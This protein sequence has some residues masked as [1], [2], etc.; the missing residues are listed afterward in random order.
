MN[1]TVFKS[2][3]SA[4][5]VCLPVV[6]IFSMVACSQDQGTQKPV[7]SNSNQA[8][9]NVL[10]GKTDTIIL[11]SANS[12]QLIL[13]PELSGRVLGA[14]IKGANDENLMWVDKTITDGSFWT[15][16]PYFW[17]AGGLRTW[18]APED[19]FFV[20][21]KK[22]ADSWF[23]PEQ[24]D[25]A[26]F[27]VIEKTGTKASFESDIVLPANIGKDYKVTLKRSIELLTS[28]PSVLGSL[29]AGIE[30]MGIDK[31]H[32]LTNNSDMVIG[33]D[34][35]YVCL[36]SLLQVNPS[37]TMLIP[38]KAGADPKTSYREYFNPLGDR[39][40]VQNGIIS[41]K[42]DGKYRSKIG[43]RP[44][45]AGKGI[46]FLR[47]NRNG[48][49]ILFVKLFPVDPNA[50]YVDKPWGKPSDYGDAIEMYND[51]GNM[52]GFTELECHGPAKKLSKG[53]TQS[54]S[55]QLHVFRG[56]IKELEAI[57]SK[58]LGTDLSKANYF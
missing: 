57:G 35:P 29:P 19:L 42:I 4:V 54:H 53:D 10:Q 13:T 24:L 30:Y 38:I 47:D 32:S 15:K 45:A 17:N 20:N 16:K 43:V 28:P 49:G 7:P 39:L 5:C 6:I 21:E 36:W 8:L 37:G 2:L 23:V 9:L 1:P 52:G 44:E 46:A 12:P 3:V 56:S 27:K 48:T 11:G 26:P 33:E 51:D 40:V 14:S 22:E 34:L 55:L 58:L 18:I 41:V 25:P 50:V 31:T